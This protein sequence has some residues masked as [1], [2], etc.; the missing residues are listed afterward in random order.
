LAYTPEWET[1]A[2]ALR[3]AVA[4]GNV[5]ADAKRDLCNAIAD[6]A[7]IVRLVL[8]EDPRK[9]LPQSIA[10]ADAFNLPARIVPTD[11][12]WRLSRPIKPWA[13]ATQVLGG[14][15]I[16]HLA[17]VGNVLERRIETIEVPSS[18]VS[19]KLGTVAQVA[20][21]PAQDR[22]PKSETG[23]KSRAVKEAMRDLWPDGIP[24]DLTPKQRDNEI[25]KWFESR[26]LSAPTSRTIQRVI[27]MISNDH[28]AD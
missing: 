27:R 9:N 12:D 24:S 15:M 3:R 7:I 8:A 4:A 18:D 26:G 5:E 10:S 6:G 21:K 1:L 14:S 25:F 23:A 16:L 22:P 20:P 19:R 2:D 28:K 17:R 13:P 11:I